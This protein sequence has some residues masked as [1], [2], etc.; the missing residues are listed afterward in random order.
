MTGAFSITLELTKFK[1]KVNPTMQSKYNL[2]VYEMHMQILGTQKKS[3]VGFE[4]S[5]ELSQPNHN[6]NLTQPQPEL[7]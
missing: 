2:I 3:A 7:G 6:L 4:F 5:R 1:S